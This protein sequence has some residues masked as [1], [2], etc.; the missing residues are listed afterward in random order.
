M[1]DVVYDKYHQ[2]KKL[3]RT[4]FKQLMK[5]DADFKENHEHMRSQLIALRQQGVVRISKKM[6]GAL[7]PCPRETVDVS[8]G[9][10]KQIVAPEEEILEVPAFIKRYGRTPQEMGYEVKSHDLEGGGVVIGVLMAKGEA[11]VWGVKTIHENSVS[12][13]TRVEDGT[14]VLALDQAATVYDQYKCL[15]DLSGPQGAISKSDLEERLAGAS[16]P[17]TAGKGEIATAGCTCLVA[18]ELPTS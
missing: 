13:N 14:E 11:G 3:K 9:V 5:T 7:P 2:P 1:C 4:E 15:P 6:L 12:H 17:Q 16:V 10:K 8:R 18:A